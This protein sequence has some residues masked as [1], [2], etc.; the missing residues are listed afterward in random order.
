MKGT[1]W[2]G[3]ISDGD[4][5][6][7]ELNDQMEYMISYQGKEY[8]GLWASINTKE[9]SLD[10][11]V[12]CLPRYVWDINQNGNLT[13]KMV[14]NILLH[15]IENLDPKKCL[16]KWQYKDNNILKEDTVFV[17]SPIPT[18]FI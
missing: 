12:S 7:I 13:K 9:A 1:A 16:L 6:R 14:E 11:M 18:E 17:V 3:Q 4:T 5:I 15:D 2:S 10:V 8:K